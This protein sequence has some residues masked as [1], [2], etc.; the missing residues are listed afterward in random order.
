MVSYSSPFESA[1]CYFILT[2]KATILS[3]TSLQRMTKDDFATSVM[4]GRVEA[5]HGSLEGHIDSGPG[6]E[7]AEDDN[8]FT[9][10]DAALPGGYEESTL[11]FQ[12]RLI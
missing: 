1:L 6:C 10:D 3:R 11:D 4:Q 12:E 2:K 8:D 7:D 5:Y 9:K